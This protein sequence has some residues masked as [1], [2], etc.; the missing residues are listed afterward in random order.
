MQ[1]PSQSEQRPTIGYVV[2]TWPRLS[3][4]FVLNEIL[5][6]ENRGLPL[7]IFSTKDPGH[8]PVHTKVAKV[9]APVAYLSFRRRVRS[10][11]LAN[12]RM[13]LRRPGAYARTLLR[14][15]GYRRP[16][17]L[18]RFFQ[19]GYLADLLH[20][21]PVTQLHAHFATGPTLVAMLA[22]E[23]VG[24]PYSFSAHARDIYVDTPPELLRAEMEGA[25]AVITCG[26][27]SRRYLASRSPDLS[28]KLRCIEHGLDLAEFTFRWPRASDP[29]P[30]LILAVGRLVE[31]KGFGDLILAADLLRRRG[32]SF[33]VQIIG[34]GPLRQA[35]ERG[36]A[37]RGLQDCVTLLGAQPHDMVRA[38][39]Q[40]AVIF[41]LPC[42][43]AGDGDRD[44]LPNVLLEAMASGLPV[45]STSIVG[46]PDLI[47]SECDGLLIPPSDP[48]A[49]ASA[50]ERLLVDPQLRDRLARAARGKIEERFS[51]HRSADRLLAVFEP[52][53]RG[54]A[55]C[56]QS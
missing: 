38:A 29:G 41:V 43:V 37:E 19:A 30:P 4:T 44:G 31:K 11:L 32:Q 10:V 16:D 54:A 34:D 22:H 23:L 3:Q 20:R 47:D 35:L 52:V 49:L 15:L 55:L 42:V 1:S 56:R 26:E 40:R 14:A 33:R 6:L 17:V 50:L 2:S 18:R 36:V 48:G 39:Y 25:R 21:N 28:G 51:I 24:I 8:E 27:Y 7:R 45:V 9:R 5:A 12:V 13:A 53:Q 46:I